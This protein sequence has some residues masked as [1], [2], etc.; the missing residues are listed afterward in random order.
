MSLKKD[1]SSDPRARA[2]LQPPCFLLL[3]CWVGYY[4]SG[5]DN[6]PPPTCP[7]TYITF[8]N[9]QI[10]RNRCKGAAV[11]EYDAIGS[12]YCSGCSALQNSNF[13]FHGPWSFGCKGLALIC[14]N[15]KRKEKN[16]N[17]FTHKFSIPK[18]STRRDSF[19]AK[20]DLIRSPL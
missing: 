4:Q 20:I 1:L 12:C 7:C 8:G 3:G 18:A 10:G 11:I 16:L 19:H 17:S 13:V 14:R 9:S 15:Y 2:G 5:T 6:P